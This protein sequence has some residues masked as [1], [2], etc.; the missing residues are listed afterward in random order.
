MAPK[1]SLRRTDGAL[2]L[3][4]LC[5]SGARM[6][7]LSRALVSGAHFG[8][9]AFGP[10]GVAQPA[11]QWSRDERTPFPHI[12]AHQGLFSTVL[13]SHTPRFSHPPSPGPEENAA[14]PSL[15]LEGGFGE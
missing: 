13:S 9:S 14:P 10:G 12:P 6:T 3:P 8:D 7:S 2:D 5:Q 4:L 15:F 11:T 1:L